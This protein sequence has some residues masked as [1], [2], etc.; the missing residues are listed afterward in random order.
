MDEWYNK[1]R[2]PVLIAYSVGDAHQLSILIVY[3]D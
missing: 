2:K 3:T 1:L